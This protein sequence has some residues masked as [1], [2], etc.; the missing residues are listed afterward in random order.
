MPGLRIARIQDDPGIWMGRGKIFSE[1]G[2]R[3]VGKSLR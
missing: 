2:G 1:R 3:Y